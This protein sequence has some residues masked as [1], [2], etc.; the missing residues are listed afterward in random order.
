MA[1]AKKAAPKKRALKHLDDRELLAALTELRW[2]L[3]VARK[4]VV[5]NDISKE[6]IPNAL[7]LMVSAT[8]YLINGVRTR[9]RIRLTR[10][11]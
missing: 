8:S 1:K 2:A 6:E 3:K 7:T 11:F 9:A 10:S 5:E 4:R